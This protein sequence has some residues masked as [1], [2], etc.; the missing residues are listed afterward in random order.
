MDYSNFVHEL[1]THTINIDN[2]VA[3]RY[4]GDFLGLL[5][6]LGIPEKYCMANL[7]VNNLNSSSDYDGTVT[8]ITLVKNEELDKYIP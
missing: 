3:N 8:D 6:H 1:P 5:L 2:V 4:K 7:T